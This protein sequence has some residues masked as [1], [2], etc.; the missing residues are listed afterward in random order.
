MANGS[1]HFYSECLKRML[2]HDVIDTS[3][4]AKLYHRDLFQTV[5]YPIGKIYEDTATTY[6]LMMECDRK[7]DCLATWQP[8]Q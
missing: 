6:R 8:Y 4:W 5:R 7:P 3:A 2:Y 1:F